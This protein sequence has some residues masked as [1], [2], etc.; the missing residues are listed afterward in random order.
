MHY[1]LGDWGHEVPCEDGMMTV[2]SYFIVRTDERGYRWVSPN[3]NPD[4]VECLRRSR[5]DLV[6]VVDLMLLHPEDFTGLQLAAVACLA[7]EKVIFNDPCQRAI[8]LLGVARR[9]CDKLNDWDAFFPSYG[10]RAYEESGA[11]LAL[12]EA[13]WHEAA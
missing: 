12:I 13:E 5:D 7:N 6:A 2:L 11:E 1:S 10:S 4:W 9:Q 8:L 3:L